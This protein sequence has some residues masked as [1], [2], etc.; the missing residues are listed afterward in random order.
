M[1]IFSIFQSGM[2][3]LKSCIIDTLDFSG[4][5]C[6]A[7]YAEKPIYDIAGYPSISAEKLIQNLR[8]QAEPFKAKHYLNQ[9]C[10]SIRKKCDHWEISTSKNVIKTKA[11]IIAA[12]GGTLEVRKPPIENISDYEN[13]SVLYHI[14]NKNIFKDKIVTIAGGGDSALDWAIILANNIAKKVYIVHRRNNFRAAPKTIEEINRLTENGT[15]ELITPYQVNQ[16]KGQNGILKEIE[17]IDLDD[18]SKCF[19]SDFLLPFFGMAMNIGP[20]N[21]WDLSIINK[22]I[23]VDPTS[24][25]TN[26]NGIY[27]IGD[28]CTYP[29]KLKLILTGFAESARACHSAYN[30]IN[31]NIHF[32]FE[33]STTKGLPKDI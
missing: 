6:S 21:T 18:N 14:K 22:H 2:L 13:I 28:I 17:V 4:G 24:M 20:I 32:H 19:K 10:N 30:Y 12:G 5:Q 27:A 33:H 29:G 26:L 15:I 16:L 31:P 25:Q 9:Q 8:K 11:I 23:E 7:L 1:G 3:G